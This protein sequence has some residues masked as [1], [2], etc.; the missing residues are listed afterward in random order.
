MTYM[1]KARPVR[2]RKKSA[3]AGISDLLE[4][5]ETK[6]CRDQATQTAAPLSQ[7]ISSLKSSWTTTGFYTPEQVLAILQEGY[8]IGSAAN[9]S[10]RAAPLSVDDARRVKDQA[11]KGVW[12][13][14]AAGDKYKVA[15]AE[16]MKAGA[17][18]VS[19]PGLRDWFIDM[20]DAARFSLIQA[21]YLEC[22]MPWLATAVI[23]FQGLFNVA[24]GVVTKIVGVVAKVG[25]TV[26]DVVGDL[27]QIWTVVKWGGLAAIGVAVALKL[28]QMRRQS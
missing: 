20:L 11:L 23:K 10:V 4:Q 18:I 19:A 16:A 12:D 15:A 9:D 27:P 5:F 22:Q 26:I 3:L 1:I 2:A 25:E 21:A 6:G 14:I 28:R 17:K 13:K 8:K 24:A 7:R